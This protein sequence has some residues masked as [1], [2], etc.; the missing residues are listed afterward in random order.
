M[1]SAVIFDLYGTL[2]EISQDSRP[3]HK[4]ARHQSTLNLRAS[5]EIA[6]TTDNQ[7]LH[8]F[9]ARLGIPS[10]TGLSVI[11]E[12]LKR[13]IARV[14]LFPDVESTLSALKQRGIATAL[15][16][17]LAT[18]YKQPLFDHQLNRF[19]DAIVFSC[20]CGL[21]KPDPKIYELALRKLRT[22]PERTIMVGDSLNS[23]VLGPA[24]LGINGI[25]LVRDGGNSI[26][27]NSI[28][29]LNSVL[30]FALS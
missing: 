22:V 29:T 8:E 5:L 21:A 23:D 3:F 15:I 9:A 19:F 11:D 10:Q 1:S 16:S 26:A 28:S 6:L 27:T 30:E 13:D 2:L 14:R 18:P 24:Q 12:E 20:D 7:T 4:V 17:N 25:H